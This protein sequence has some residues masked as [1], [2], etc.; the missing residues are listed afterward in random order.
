[1]KSHYFRFF[2]TTYAAMLFWLPSHSHTNEH[3]SDIIV[4]STVHNE[5]STNHKKYLFFFNKTSLSRFLSDSLLRLP[6]VNSPADE[7]TLSTGAEVAGIARI[8]TATALIRGY[9][10]LWLF[11]YSSVS[12]L[13]ARLSTASKYLVTST[14]PGGCFAV[15]LPST[16]VLTPCLSTKTSWWAVRSHWHY[17]LA[18]AT[19]FLDV[20]ASHFVGLPDPFLISFNR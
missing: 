5:G 1:M 8:S 11:Q 16:F 4:T 14:C 2:E 15:F 20:G 10:W 9:L 3:I 7:K 17:T 13:S 18:H 6:V 12:T 19:L